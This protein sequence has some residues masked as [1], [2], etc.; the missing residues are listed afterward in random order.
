MHHDVL[1]ID[2][3]PFAIARTF[4][5]EGTEPRGLA[6]LND[7]IGDRADVPVGIT[8][9]DD[10]GVSDVSETSYIQ[11]LHVHGFHVIE[12]E[13][14]DRLQRGRQGALGG[15]ARAAGGHVLK[16]ALLRNG[17]LRSSGA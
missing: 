6:L 9:G 4:L 17:Q 10:E 8:R 7:S 15:A 2:E 1:Q 16:G 5:A 3:N 14:H 13:R 11:H 12:R